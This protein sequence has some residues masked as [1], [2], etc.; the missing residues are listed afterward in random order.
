MK[1]GE[2]GPTYVSIKKS[3]PLSPF[4]KVKK[5]PD[6]VGDIYTLP[7]PM[8]TK[9]KQRKNWHKILQKY[10]KLPIQQTPTK[11]SKIRQTGTI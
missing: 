10:F 2:R 1:L 7:P 4:I 3:R 8:G 5:N 11:L 9:R 6:T